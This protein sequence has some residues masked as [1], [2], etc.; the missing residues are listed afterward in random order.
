[1]EEKEYRVKD[2]INLTLDRMKQEGLYFAT[3][4]DTGYASGKEL[5]KLD[6]NGYVTEKTIDRIVEEVIEYMG[7]GAAFLVDAVNQW[8]EDGITEGKI[9]YIDNLNMEFDDNAI[10]EGNLEIYNGIGKEDLG[11]D[12]E[13][14]E[15]EIS[16]EAEEVKP[17]KKTE[18]KLVENGEY[19]TEEE[20]KNRLKKINKQLAYIRRRDN[21]SLAIGS[22]EE[23]SELYAER[24]KLNGKLRK[25]RN[26]KVDINNMSED[27]AEELKQKLLDKGI[28]DGKE[29]SLQSALQIYRAYHMENESKKVEESISKSNVKEALTK[30]IISYMK[31]EGFEED[32]AEDY[33]IVEVRESETGDLVAEVRAE[34]DFEGSMKLAE[35][36][37]PVV[38]KY[39]KEAYFDAVTNGIIEAVIEPKGKITESSEMGYVVYGTKDGVDDIVKE[40]DNKREANKWLKANKERLENEGYTE[41]EVLSNEEVWLDY[42]VDELDESKVEKKTLTEGVRQRLNERNEQSAGVIEQALNGITDQTSEQEAGII[43]KTSELFQSLSDRGYD[44]QVS[45]DNGESTSSISIGQQGAN[46]LITITDAEQPLRAFASG[47]FE[48]NDDSLKM[49]KSIME[50][51][52]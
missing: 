14:K 44:V 16:K 36:L 49:I 52:K 46:V 37:D 11:T 12:T 45:F 29:D 33:F 32:E 23:Q 38:R 8:I 2:V 50:V 43:T 24:N 18:G 48:I 47:N 25:I 28:W 27:E 30:K 15:E 34:L 19:N 3:K 4:D 35:I 5:Y 7:D 10:V 26:K 42:D 39:D 1:M 51:L 31:S 20:I 6:E 22:E 17:E 9:G 13:P 41:L 40:F 21:V